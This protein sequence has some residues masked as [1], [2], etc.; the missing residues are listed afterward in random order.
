MSTLLCSCHRHPPAELF[1]QCRTQTVPPPNSHF[2]FLSPS[3]WLPPFPFLSLGIWLLWVPHITVI[4]L[5]VLFC[6]WLI[7]LSLILFIVHLC[8]SRHQKFLPF[9]IFHFTYMWYFVYLF[10]HWWTYEVFPP[11]AIVNNA[12]VNIPISG[13]A[14]LCNSSI[15]NFLKSYNTLF[16]FIRTGYLFIYLFIYL[17]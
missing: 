15:F 6:D 12:A 13:I 5:Y 14:G 1:S 7:S 8:Y 17:F 10:V 9:I 4:I 2:P 3:S 16:L 11:L